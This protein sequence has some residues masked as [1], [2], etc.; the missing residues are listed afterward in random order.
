[1]EDSFVNRLRPFRTDYPGLD[2]TIFL[3]LLILLGVAPIVVMVAHLFRT[4][5]SHI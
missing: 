5:L 1:M 2:G 3:A 4:L